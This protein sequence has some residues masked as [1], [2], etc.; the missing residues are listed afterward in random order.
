MLDRLEIL[1]ELSVENRTKIVLLVMDGLGGLPGTG[2]Q[3]ELEAAFTPNLDALASRAELGLLEMVDTG[4]TPGSGPGHLGLFGYDPLRFQ[5][6]RG[7]LEALGTGAHV[8][9]GELCARG[10]LCTWG[11]KDLV[12]DRR[13]GRINTGSSAGIIGKLAERIKAI[14]GFGVRFYPGV[15][16]RFAV[17]FSG[18]GLSDKVTDADPQVEGR[19]MIWR[20]P[21]DPSAE[22]TSRLVNDLIRKVREVLSD[23]PKANG[24]LLR[25]ISGAP[26]IPPMPDL[27]RFRPAA[28]ATYPLYKGLAR[29]VGMEVLPAGKTVEGLFQALGTNWAAFDFF[30]VHVKYAD[31]RGEDGDFDAKREVI[32]KVDSLVPE[33]LEL[34]PDVLVVTGDHSTPSVMASH[35]WHPSPFL[36]ASPFVRSDGSPSFGERSCARGSLGIMPA[37]KLMG[38]MLA[39]A[40][41]LSKYGA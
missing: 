22:R 31:S 16:H 17:V 6:G 9:A 19:P 5:I 13:A 37:Y 34:E 28:I 8:Q 25:G 18:E 11:E 27:Y 3:T 21:L 4:V 33:V 2:G 20:E 40:R 30:Y 36:L 26:D 1:K 32:E 41:R 29:I 14:D 12:L 15:E 10:N 23:E 24:C 39:H 38:L 35:S 7:I